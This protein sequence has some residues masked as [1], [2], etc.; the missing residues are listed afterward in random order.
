MQSFAFGNKSIKKHLQYNCHI[1]NP[2]PGG[3]FRSGCEISACACGVLDGA[4]TLLLRPYTRLL[5]FLFNV[6]SL[7]ASLM[8]QVVKN[9][10]PMQET[11]EMPVQSLDWKDLLE[12]GLATHS[13]ILA[14]RTLWTEESGGLQSMG[15]QELDK[16]ERTERDSHTHARDV[17]HPLSSFSGKSVSSLTFHYLLGGFPG[18]RELWPHSLIPLLHAVDGG[19]LPE[20]HVSNHSSVLSRS[21]YQLLS[22]TSEVQTWKCNSF[23]N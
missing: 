9:L 7:G 15:S 23:F 12:E 10:P 16:T 11:Q 5:L 22:S 17:N 19:G 4:M 1:Q 18:G 6:L 14:Q 20:T 21:L 8:A 3:V 2:T 13:S